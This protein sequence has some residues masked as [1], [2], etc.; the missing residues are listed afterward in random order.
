MLNAND[1]RAAAVRFDELASLL[2]HEANGL[3]DADPHRLGG[4]GPGFIEATVELHQESARLKTAGRAL[5]MLASMCRDRA[6]A[7]DAQPVIVGAVTYP[8]SRNW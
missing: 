5:A 7:C 1:Y 2:T 8:G 3:A 4:V 6:V